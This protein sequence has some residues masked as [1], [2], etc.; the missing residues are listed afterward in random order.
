MISN[1]IQ[2]LIKPTLKIHQNKLIDRLAWEAVFG[3]KADKTSAR[4]LIREIAQNL[5]IKPA[6]I[7]NLYFARG[8]GK[9]PL[10]FTVPAFNLRGLTY[11]IARA[12]FSAA[13]KLQAGTF[14]F[15]LARSEMNYT[16][17]P[18]EEYA[19]IILAAAIRQNWQGPVFIQADHFQIK[20]LKPGLPK[21]DEVQNL[22]QLI[23]QAIKAGFFNIDL[24]LSTLVDLEKTTE[25]DQ[26]SANIKYSLELT[27]FIRSIEP[28]NI[29]ISIGGEIGH[30]GGKNN[31]LKD[32]QAYIQG[33]NA[34]LPAKMPGLSKI[35]LQTGASHGGVVLPDGALADVKVDFSLLSQISQTCR[36]QYQI[37]GAVQHGA[38][39]LPD[40]Y[41]KQFP[42][43]ETLEIHLA[44]GL[45]NIILDHPKFPRQL[46]RK[47]YAWLDQEKADQRRKNQTDKQFHYQFR[48]HAWGQFK[49][50]CWQINPSIRKALRTTLEKKL[51]FIFQELNVARTQ[52]LVNR[53]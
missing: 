40:Q 17:Q 16:S 48:K 13:S 34:G 5:N 8:Q 33:F 20:P 23:R 1:K 18:P 22:K 6:S 52:N 50:Q 15:E 53:F 25:A 12:V 11:D 36:E 44:T 24:D 2:N 45:Q 7:N 30:I 4:Q 10:D 41:F 3:E 32:F 14:I 51:A 38:S 9:T 29:T 47:M 42:Q 49:K 43:A 28:P 21:K 46:L 39:T 37:G 26:Q 31:T 35:S 27:K 19:A